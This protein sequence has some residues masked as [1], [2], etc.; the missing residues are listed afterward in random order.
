MTFFFSAVD[1]FEATDEQTVVATLNDVWVPFEADLALFG[2]S[3][4]PQGRVRSAG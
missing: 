2:A 4:Y 1:N 3:I